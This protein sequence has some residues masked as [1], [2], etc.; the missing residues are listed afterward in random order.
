[1]NE[2]I[3]VEDALREM[4]DG[5]SVRIEKASFFDMG[6][7]HVI[8]HR[9]GGGDN[10]LTL[11]EFLSIYKNTRF[12]VDQP[13]VKNENLNPRKEQECAIDVNENQEKINVSVNFKM[14]REEL[15]RL[16]E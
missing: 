10:I 4:F 16:F 5:R 1:M 7:R 14:L 9:G 8:H 6:V 13:V 15:R 2:A 3:P 12:T 11:V